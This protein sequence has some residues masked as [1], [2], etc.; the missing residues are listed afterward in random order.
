MKKLIA[1]TWFL[2]QL[3]FGFSQIINDVEFRSMATSNQD[4][5]TCSF[6]ISISDSIQI[7][8]V[9]IELGSTEGQNDLINQNFDF[10]SNANLPSGFS[11]LRIGYRVSLE[12]GTIPTFP[13]FF[14]RA[15]L[16][17]SNGQYTS[18]FSFTAN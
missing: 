1:L 8:K 5:L 10:D 15:R 3:T 7:D 9:E 2:L 6:V 4:S 12:T 14:G 13:T 16:K 11:Y 18:Y 17:L